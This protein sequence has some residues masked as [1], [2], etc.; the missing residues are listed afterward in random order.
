[1]ENRSRHYGDIK[2]WIEKVIDSCETMEQIKTTKKLISNFIWGCFYEKNS[3]WI[4]VWAIVQLDDNFY[5]K[6]S[7]HTYLNFMCHY[8]QKL[9][10]LNNSNNST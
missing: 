3:P 1:M 4:F 6:L 9:I 7:K 8:S 5:I 10:K 2:L